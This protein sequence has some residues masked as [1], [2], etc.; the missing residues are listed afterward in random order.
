MPELE[1][2]AQTGW[3][4]VQQRASEKRCLPSDVELL[5]VFGSPELQGLYG[6]KPIP[7]TRDYTCGAAAVASVLRY[8]GE[9]SHEMQAAQSMGTNSIVGTEVQK[10]TSFLKR[11]GLKCWATSQTPVRHIIDRV[12]QGK[13]TLVDWNDYGGHWVVVCGY[14]PVSDAVILADPARPRSK[15]SAFSRKFFHKHWHCPAFGASSPTG[16]PGRYDRLAVFVD[17]YARGKQA[18]CHGN[19]Y[20]RVQSFYSGHRRTMTKEPAEFQP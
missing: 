16:E 2:E 17:R 9:E 10:M 1:I 3:T 4:P 7:Q 13:I 6:F 15:F 11:R 5:S 12:R 19:T 20:D 14:D 8:M 18:K